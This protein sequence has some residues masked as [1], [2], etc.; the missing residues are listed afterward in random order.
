MNEL[1]SKLERISFPS[2]WGAFV[3]LPNP[4]RAELCFERGQIEDR[5]GIILPLD[6]HLIIL[7]T[8]LSVAPPNQ[9]PLFLPMAV[10]Q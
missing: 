5:V 10:S 8:K 6:P 1:R 3:H 2:L 4:H 7:S 9:L